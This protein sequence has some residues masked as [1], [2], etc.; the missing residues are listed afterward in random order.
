MK[1]HELLEK[2]EESAKDIHIPHK[3]EPGQIETQLKQ[4][5]QIKRN[6]YRL[7]AAAACL[8]LCFGAAS[9][10]YSRNNEQHRSNARQAEDHTKEPEK[11][12]PISEIEE[13]P[14]KKI[15]KMFTLASGY[16]DVYDTLHKSDEFQM[17]MRADTEDAANEN[18][19]SYESSKT[20]ED[21]DNRKMSAKQELTDSS[22]YSTTNLQAAGVDESDI[23]KTDGRY[24]YVVQEEQVRILD[25]QDKVPRIAAAIVPDM[26]DL[27][28]ICEMY[29]AD[30]TLTLIIQSEK[31]LMQEEQ[32]NQD[33]T[34]AKNAASKKADF[35]DVVMYSMDTDAVTKVL[36]YDIS[37]PQQPVL[38]DAAEQDGWYKTSRKIGSRL[39][40][41]TTQS[42]YETIGMSRKK[43][44][45]DG[46]ES[47]WVPRVN[48]E[49]I[50]PDCI[51]LPEKGNNGI[52]MAS[53]DLNNHCSVLDT[54][55]LVNN[56]CELYVSQNSVYLY[57]TDY[58]NGHDKTRIARF[59]LDADGMM[60]AKAA[61]SLKGSI[62]DTFAIYERDSY[63]QVL[64]S[65]TGLDPWENRVYVLDENMKVTGRLA[66]LA[67]GERIYSARFIGTAGYFVTYRNTD[68][69][70]SVDFSNP[71]KP[72]VI[73]QLKVTGFS[74][75]LQFWGSRRLLGIG[76]E[77]DPADGRT[78]G[79]KL[80][81]FDISN[82]SKV[83][84]TA[85]L[86]LED[87][88]G[89]ACM[90]D[91]KCVL[92]DPEKNIIAFTTENYEK[93]GQLDYRVFSFEK[94]NFAS[95]LNRVLTKKYSF[96]SDGG[97]WRSLYI[98][99]TLYLVSPRKA[100]AFDMRDSYHEIGKTALG[101]VQK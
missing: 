86:V 33:E 59:A 91:Y 69:L 76:Y 13:A 57:Y 11:Q 53:I 93:N 6:R 8:C 21:L 44:L 95:R 88:D 14:R 48:G 24:L 79:V 23:V 100:I 16:G 47:K 7:A 45:Q 9:A 10:A 81:M 64:T 49:A 39:Y 1:E 75:Y 96:R 92:A 25:T 89:G 60:R 31:T 30:Q 66:G 12:Q 72:K 27:D 90:Y 99:D 73:G 56:Y 101:T 52:I 97:R 80:S 94:G 2:L 87:A 17:W 41:F 61:A 26:E 3:L 46:E 29:A 77:T 67:E 98:G 84:E 34:E 54:K 28:R 22:G 51:Y 15:G 5:Q 55:L 62:Q 43:A 63:L 4:R 36:T 40:L 50:R 20:V 18:Y 74:E 85:R 32:D 42:M 70:F 19:G 38:Q 83:T 71:N 78:I 35:A 68:P 37:Q 65:E 58:A 82:P